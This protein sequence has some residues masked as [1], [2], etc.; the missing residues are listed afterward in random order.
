MS[1]YNPYMKTPDFGQGTQDIMNQIMQFMLM[2]QMMGPQG[3]QPGGA[4]PGQTQMPPPMSNIQPNLGQQITSQAPPSMGQQQRP[5]QID[6]QMIMMLLQM[7]Q[8]R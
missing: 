3:G 1:F 8:R 7:M 4:P 5:P 2:K 6:P